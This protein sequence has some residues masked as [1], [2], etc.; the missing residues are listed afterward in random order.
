MVFNLLSGTPIPTKLDD[1]QGLLKFLH[2]S[3][4]SESLAWQY[5][6]SKPFELRN[7]FGISNMKELLKT[8]MMRHTKEVIQLPPRTVQIVWLSF[9]KL[10]FDQYN[11]LQKGV[12]RVLKDSRKARVLIN[13]LRQVNKFMTENSDDLT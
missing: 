2:H 4:Y 8:I 10:E 7:L 5:C 12:N 9:K 3:P 1:F 11:N 13:K 6:I